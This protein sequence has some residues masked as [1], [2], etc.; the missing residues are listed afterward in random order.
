MKIDK[1]L[2][3]SPVFAIA[4]AARTVEANLNRALRGEGLGFFQGLLLVAV[5]FE[6]AG[7]VSPSQLAASFS[8]TRGNVSHG[9]S[10]L[11]ARGLVKRQIDAEDARVLRISIRPDGRRC[12]MRLIKCFNTLEAKIEGALGASQVRAAIT[13]MSRVE[14]LS[15]AV[16]AL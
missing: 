1:F 13:V 12:A 3:E 4:K 6:E 9:L 10:A 8:T 2:A 16:T 11:E 14:E 15:E 5:F 7:R